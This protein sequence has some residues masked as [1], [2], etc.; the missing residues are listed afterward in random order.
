MTRKQITI[1]VGLSDSTIKRCGED[2]KM[3]KLNNRKT[4]QKR[5]TTRKSI[6][7]EP[8][9]KKPKSVK[10]KKNNKNNDS[11]VGFLLDNVHQDKN[12]KLTSIAR[13]IVANV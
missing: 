8:K 2:I 6:E 10:N 11:K 3:D 9:N 1:Q 12:T 5:T 4:Y 13:K 7:D